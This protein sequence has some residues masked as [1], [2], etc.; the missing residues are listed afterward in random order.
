M[1][2]L[3]QDTIAAHVD[4]SLSLEERR[5]ADTHLA[6]CAE[7]RTEIREVHRALDHGPRVWA[8]RTVVVS[9]LA[10]AALAGLLLWP[11]AV[12]MGV[13]ALD[14]GVDGS[15]FRSAP[16]TDEAL[17]AI[18][19][20]PPRWSD[21]PTRTLTLAWRSVEGASTYRVTVTD[22][23][24]APLWST[25]TTD[26][27]AT[28]PADVGVEADGAYFWFVDATLVE[29]GSASTGVRTLVVP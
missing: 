4:R 18:E 29:G 11:G 8:R 21:E 26:S 22:A 3:S 20:L 10:A 16:A 14:E 9:T 13:P 27:V 6:G 2:H 5:V 15:P 24:G 12:P 17:V 19:P 7:C 28:V 25:E 1:N 23:A